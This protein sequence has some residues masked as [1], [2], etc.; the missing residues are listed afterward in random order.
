MD[1]TSG[2]LFTIFLSALLQHLKR[3]PPTCPQCLEPVYWSDALDFA[4]DSLSRYTV[5]QEG[6][7]TLLD[8]LL[9]FRSELRASAS[10][11]RAAQAAQRG[12]EATKSMKASLGRTVYVG[13]AEQ[14]LGV[15][16]DPGA[17]GLAA[18]FSGLS[19]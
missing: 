11:R 18:F 10:C 2:A 1:G 3:C 6:D 7:R 15:I 5:A 9:P 12:A 8:A 13:G 17:W 19:A 4:I 16:P 14:W